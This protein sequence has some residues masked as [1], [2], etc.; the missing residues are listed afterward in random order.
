[1]WEERKREVKSFQL[2]DDP[3]FIHIIKTGFVDRYYVVF[4]D[5]YEICNGMQVESYTKKQVKEKFNID[6]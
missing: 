3:E 4:E 1:M 6:L 5:A 2:S